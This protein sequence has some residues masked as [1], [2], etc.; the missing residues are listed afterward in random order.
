MADQIFS[1]RILQFQLALLI[2]ALFFA[3]PCYAENNTLSFL[4]S[5]A[6]QECHPDEYLSF[7]THA[8]KS[9]SFNSVTKLEKGLTRDEV[10]KCYSC[11]TTGYGKPGGFIDSEQTPHLKNAGCEV[12]HGPGSRHV[13]TLRADDIKGILT[14]EDCKQCHISERIKAFRYKPMI[15]GGAH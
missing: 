4:G 1:H 15:R 13:Q 9:R 2:F 12:C 10:E 6:C 3:P 8:K 14:T 7:I 11:H 5:E